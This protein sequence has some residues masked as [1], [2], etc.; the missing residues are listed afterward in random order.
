VSDPDNVVT[1]R[2][3]WVCGLG[4]C[5][6]CGDYTVTVAPADM[7]TRLECGNCGE[8]CVAVIPLE[9]RSDDGASEGT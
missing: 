7:L 5:G 1:L 4:V 3:G 8:W 9:A 6:A 2:P